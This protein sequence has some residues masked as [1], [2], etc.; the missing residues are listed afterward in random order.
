[1]FKE[2]KFWLRRF[3]LGEITEQELSFKLWWMVALA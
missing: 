3:E 1:M 2:I